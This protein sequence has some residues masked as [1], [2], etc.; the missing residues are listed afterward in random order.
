MTGQT[1]TRDFEV[2]S[3]GRTLV[4]SQNLDGD[5]GVVVWDAALVLC[6][7]LNKHI[8]LVKGRS[9]VELGAGVGACGL[10]AAVLGA[11]YVV[12]TDLERLV[13]VAERNI[14]ENQHLLSEGTVVE[15][16]T[17]DWVNGTWTF[18]RPIDLVLIADCLYY[19]ESIDPLLN[20]CREALE[21]NPNTQIIMSHEDRSETG[22][23]DV[24]DHFFQEIAKFASIKEIRSADL[25]PHWQ[26]PM[27]HVHVFTHKS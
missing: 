9:I 18:K 5:V 6:A 8:G 7:Y 14:V 2:T 19:E 13:P 1:F 3:V 26:D 23:Q 24:Q 20:V 17:L 15:A 11:Q 25:D 21:T 10:T 12:L 22:K 16:S 4:F 27:I